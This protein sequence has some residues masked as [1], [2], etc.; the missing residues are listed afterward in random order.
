MTDGYSEA[1]KDDINSVATFKPSKRNKAKKAID[2]WDYFKGK[3]VY[4][5]KL[6]E[7]KCL[8][9]KLC[10]SETVEWGMKCRHGDCTWYCPLKLQ[11]EEEN[12]RFK[13]LFDWM[14][15]RQ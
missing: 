10:E 5:P 3:D 6:S 12:R 11:R 2:D 8:D 9:G 13:E 1:H 14:A 4:P 15:N 7:T